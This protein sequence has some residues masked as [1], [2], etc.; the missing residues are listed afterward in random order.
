MNE[1]IDELNLKCS[2]CS[3]EYKKPAEFRKWQEESPQV[4]Y[5]WSL[6]YCD[7]CRRKKESDALKKLP[8][9][10]KILTKGV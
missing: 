6:E 4:F 9:I 10:L 2:T 3:I 8:E 7:T 5:Q 1:R